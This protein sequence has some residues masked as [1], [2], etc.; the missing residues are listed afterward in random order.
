PRLDPRVLLL[1]LL[2][3][4]GG[5]PSDRLLHGLRPLSP[6]FGLLFRYGAR[7]ATRTVDRLELIEVRREGE[8]R[9]DLVGH[10]HG[11]VSR[12]DDLLERLVLLVDRGLL[13]LGLGELA[14]LLPSLEHAFRRAEPA[15]GCL[16][17]M[18]AGA[19]ARHG[20]AFFG[21]VAAP[22]VE[23]PDLLVVG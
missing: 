3:H 18:E 23:V 11:L 20:N 13:R 21:R 16:E 6:T 4:R 12:V 14:L 8:R 9:L 5:S 19:H 2:A 15:D 1:E 22:G 10:L 17:L 7:L